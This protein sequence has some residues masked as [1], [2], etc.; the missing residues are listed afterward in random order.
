[1]FKEE[2]EFEY[3]EYLL[4]TKVVMHRNVEKIFNF[5]ISNW[6][7]SAQLESARL[8]STQLDSAQLNS[9]RL[10]STQVDSAGTQLNLTWLSS[11]QP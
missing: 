4:E 1:M 7:I 10:S 8:S 5:K 6:L 2:K 11:A 9:A 3:S